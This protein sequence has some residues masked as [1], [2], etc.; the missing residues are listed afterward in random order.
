MLLWEACR[1]DPDPAAFRRALTGGA[2]IDRA[3]AAATDHRIAPLLWRAF[4][5]ADAREDLRGCRAP[6]CGMA[7]AF[8]MEALLLI[9]RAVAL[10]VRP[11]TDAGL[12]PVV[13]KGPAVAARYPEPGLRPMEDIDLLLPRRDHLRAL[14]ALAAAGWRVVRPGGGDHYDTVLTHAEVPSLSLELHY[15]L[16]GTSQRV[17]ALD[18]EELWERRR[19]IACAGTPAFGLPLTDELVVLAAHAGKPHHG[20]VR[21]AWIADLAMIVGDAAERGTPVD[22]ERVRAVATGA[23]CLTVVA[24][25]LAL[26]GRVGVEPPAGLFPVPTRG[27]RG[28]AMDRLLSVTWPLNHLELPG[29][30]LNY[31]LTDARAQRLKI[32][33]VLLASGHRV[34]T[35]ARH[36]VSWPRRARL[37]TS[38]PAGHVA[39]GWARVPLSLPSESAGSGAGEDVPQRRQQRAV[40]RE[41]G[42][43]VGVEPPV[44]EPAEGLGRQ[45]EVGRLPRL[46]RHQLR[47]VGRETQREVP[48]GLGGAHGDGALLAVRAPAEAHNEREVV[49]HQRRRIGGQAGA[50]IQHDRDVPGVEGVLVQPQ[51]HELV[52]AEAEWPHGEGQPCPLGL[53]DRLIGRHQRLVGRQ[54]VAGLGPG[55]LGVPSVPDRLVEPLGWSGSR[56]RILQ[57]PQ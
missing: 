15:G 16:E 4:G 54:R 32:L 7:D 53:V 31:A 9:P 20:F 23:R 41:G 27:W 25:A 1:R 26:A 55:R 37:A 35:R 46:P 12:E 17:T 11:L 3:V 34:G 22:W 5:A 24:A 43:V 28:V 39:P 8:R 50:G 51:A 19:P 13:F 42:C 57:A 44:D 21:L 10:A 40:T 33:L 29:Y 2:D 48:P 45:L 6:L 56:S 49:D 52:E 14:A 18:P 30:H 36:A 47:P 38:R